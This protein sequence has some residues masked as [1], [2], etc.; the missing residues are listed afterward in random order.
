[1]TTEDCLPQRA[2]QAGYSFHV[3]AQKRSCP[4]RSKS[5]Q[6][7][8]FLNLFKKLFPVFEG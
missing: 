3:I 1:M 7:M 2:V 5:A 8:P 6:E 4:V